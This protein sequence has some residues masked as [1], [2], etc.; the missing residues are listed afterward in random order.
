M[1]ADPLG[2]KPVNHRPGPPSPNPTANPVGDSGT[3]RCAFSW[4]NS[5]DL[6]NSTTDASPQICSLDILHPVGG[7]RVTS[8]YHPRHRKETD[9]SVPGRT[10]V[11]GS[12]A[13]LA[14]A[15]GSVFSGIDSQLPWQQ[16]PASA[17]TIPDRS[18][19]SRQR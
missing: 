19:R 8:R 13:V 10:P 3:E 2:V 1:T 4:R 7:G 16:D 17:A 6:A 9:W 18:T 14:I 12:L 11:V 15:G 5:S